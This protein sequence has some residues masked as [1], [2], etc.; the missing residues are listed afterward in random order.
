MDIN[1]IYANQNGVELGFLTHSTL[2]IDIGDTND[3]EVTMKS[4]EKLLD[5]CY[6][7]YVN[8][9]E[10]G[11]IIS[12]IAVD[13]SNNKITYSGRTWRGLLENYIIR[14]S[15][16]ADYRVVSGTV[17]EI[18]QAL[19][20]EFGI[21]G[22]YSVTASA[23]TVSGFQFDRYCTFLAGITKMLKSV[24]C[25]L[26]ISCTNGDIFLAA[27]PIT[28]YSD[29]LEYSQDGNINFKVEDD[30]GGINHL[31]CLGSG[32]LQNRQIL[33]LYLQSD[34]TIGTTPYYTGTSERAD[35]YD[36]SSVESAAELEKSGRER[37]QELMDSKKFE[38]SI[39]GDIQVELGDIVGGRERITGMSMKAAITQKIVKYSDGKIKVSYTVK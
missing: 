23:V 22:L 2:D 36:F 34:G 13:T 9:T 39:G 17:S 29:T 26:N 32:Q 25:R 31:L 11:G 3:F 24:N 27:V 10:Y 7:V 21:S 38:M 8:G 1:M 15:S 16:G 30:R 14:P 6:S 5:F 12:K 33:D 28:D 20:A 18:I 37:F 35:V 19:I 4:K